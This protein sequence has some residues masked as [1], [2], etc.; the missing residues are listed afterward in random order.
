MAEDKPLK[1]QP[2]AL[3]G[4]W[5]PVHDGTMLV[6]GDFQV[7]QNMR[8]TDAPGVKSIAGMTKINTNAPAYPK[9]RSGYHFRKEQPAESHV[10]VQAFNSALTDSKVYENKT[11]I[12]TAGD[13]EATAVFTDSSGAG[14]ARFS[15]APDGCMTYSNGVETCVWGGNEYRTAAFLVGNL[16]G[17]IN[18]DYTPLINNTLDDANNVATMQRVDM[19]PDAN[20]MFLLHLDNNVTDSSPTTPHEVTNTN[21]TFSNSI[22]RFGYSAV[23]NGTNANLTTPYDSD[24]NLNGGVFTIDFWIRGDWSGLSAGSYEIYYQGTDANN[25]L[26]ITLEKTSGGLYWLQFKIVTAGGTTVIMGSGTP[27]LSNATWYHVAVVENGNNFYFFINGI[28]RTAISDTDRALDTYTSAVYI[29]SNTFKGYIDEFRVS[30]SARWTST[31]TPSLAPFSGYVSTLFLGSTRPIQGA[32]FYLTTNCVKNDTAAT[33]YGSEWIGTSWSPL[34]ITDGTRDTATLTKTLAKTGSV[35]FSTTVSTSKPRIIYNEYLY[36][37]LFSFSGIDTGVTISYCTV[38]APMQPILDL[39][40]G[41]PRGVQGFFKLTSGIYTDETTNVFT[42][43]YDSTNSSTWSDISSLATTSSLIIGFAT[44]TAGMQFGL[45]TAKINSNVSVM[46]VSYWNGSAWVAVDAL[47]DQTSITGKSLS[48]KG[49][50]NWSPPSP[51]SEFQ[52]QINGGPLW[53]YYQVTFS[54]TLSANVYLDNVF[55]I[56]APKTILA[57]AFT[58]NWQNRLILI[59]ETKGQKNA[60]KIGGFGAVCIFNGQDTAYTNFGDDSLPTAAGALFTRYT[61]SFYDTLVITKKSEAWV[62]DGTDV[63]NYRLYKISDIYGCVAPETFRVFPVSYGLAPGISRHVAIWQSATGIVLFDGNTISQIDDDI[64]NYFDV[65][66]SECIRGSLIDKSVAFVDEREQEY[67]WVFASGPTATGLN[68]ELVFSMRKKGWYKVDRV[69]ANNQL[70]CGIPVKDTLGGAYVYGGLSTG[71]LERLEYG[72]T[73]DTSDM[74]F[75]FKT[76]D[77]SVNWSQEFEA[78]WVKLITRAKLSALNSTARAILSAFIDG[79]LTAENKTMTVSLE[80]TVRKIIQATHHCG[81]G[82]ATF[83]SF[84]VQVTA[85]DLVIPFEPIGLSLLVKQIRP[86]FRPLVS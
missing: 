47:L 17:T 1:P 75:T 44:Q 82:P 11:A 72:T 6:D 86:D 49:W 36:W 51:A 48:Q 10:L 45:V 59:G 24:F 13:F 40:D 3:S 8:Y 74:V 66:K 37:Y 14:T 41:T 39:W 29:G 80:S 2:L 20:T 69:T 71:Y 81:Y 21:V 68:T 4:K 46:S 32:K 54:A 43:D 70:Q 50:I 5:R 56:P 42:Q 28:L 65:N 12:P 77:Y 64:R 58:A 23:F 53:Y 26:N 9:I 30:N 73:F 34:T 22:Y 18:Y 19:T 7:L 63:T 57:H 16:D 33:A 76:K 61:G 52:Q 85:N 38:D 31:F 15:D 83:C 62:L 67:H 79:N 27:Y 55:G 78:E 84:Q 60:L 35:T 25:Y